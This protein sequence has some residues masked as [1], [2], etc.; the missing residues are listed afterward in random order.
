MARN[1][2]SGKSPI[3]SNKEI[4]DSVTLLVSA[5]V[6]TNVDIATQTNDYAGTV[7]TMP[8]G[9]SILGFYVESSYNLSQVIVGKFDWY[10]CKRESGRVVTDFPPPGATGGTVLRKSIFHERKGVLD[11][12]TTSNAGGQTSKSVEFLKIPKGFQ[13]MGE[14]DKWTIRAAGTTNYSFC[15]KVIYKWYI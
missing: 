12:G 2:R 1:R 5:G 8:L 15:L 10:L 14:L 6:I 9:A 11:G 4:V 13:R 7:G 3:T